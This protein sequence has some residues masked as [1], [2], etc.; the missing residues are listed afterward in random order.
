MRL[1]EALDWL[2]PFLPSA[3]QLALGIPLALGYAAAAATLAGWLNR[4]GI[5][6]P[7]TRKIFHFLI[8]SA[9]GVVQPSWGLRGVVVFGLVNA[10]LVLYAVARGEG[11]A[12]YDALARPSD[13]PH[14]RL[15]IVVPLITTALGG[16]LANVWFGA[17]APVG[18]MVTGWGDAVG[19]PV[20]TRWGRH[21][22]RVPS[23]AGVPATR[24]LEGSTAVLVVGTAA[25][26]V[27]LLALGSS[28]RRNLVRGG[29]NG[30]RGRLHAR[31]RQPHRPAG[32]RGD[33]LV[34]PVLAQGTK[35][36]TFAYHVLS[37][38]GCVIFTPPPIEKPGPV[39]W[40]KT[41]TG[42]M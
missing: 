36:S 11:F 14:G 9:A 22:Y 26:T 5:R 8:I 10:S 21:R 15:Y 27:V 23:L 28:A 1:D 17:F 29:W 13:A 37:S 12:F 2:S 16:V 40:L 32:R 34:A 24:S 6:A 35:S 25:A 42:P 41:S 3:R 19:E 4:R 7:Y 38:S 30:R 33:G 31:P 20:G 18:Y 39:G